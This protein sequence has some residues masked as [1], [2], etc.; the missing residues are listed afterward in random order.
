M[1]KPRPFSKLKKVIES[2]FDEK[3]TMQ[4]CCISYPIRGQWGHNNS[5]PRYYVKLGKEIIWD[6]PKDFNLKDISFYYWAEFNH[7]NEIV[8]EYIDTPIENLLNK[9]FTHEKNDF[10]H[11]QINPNEKEILVFEYQLTE[12]FKA[13]D[14]RIG[15]EKL[16]NWAKEISNPKV[17]KILELRFKD[18]YHETK[19]ECEK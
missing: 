14:R 8:R 16:L 11:Q 17:D 6:F 10:M 15:K 4:F 18:Q 1:A 13:A 2:L 3:L 12:L 9:E 19:Y 5:I 7:I